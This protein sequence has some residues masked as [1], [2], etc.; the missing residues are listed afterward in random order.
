MSPSSG[1]FEMSCSEWCCKRPASAKLSPLPSSTEVSAR[2]TMQG[3][4]LDGL[5]GGDG[6]RH[7]AD[8]SAVL[9]SGRI[10]RLRWLASMIVGV[11]ARLTP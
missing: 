5:F 2:R 3:R 11:K 8:R 9:T 7:R 10:R 1:T 4:D 6:Q